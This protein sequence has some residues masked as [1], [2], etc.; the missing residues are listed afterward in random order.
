MSLQAVSNK[1]MPKQLAAATPPSQKYNP[2]AEQAF[3]DYWSLGTGRSLEKLVVFYQQTTHKVTTNF[4]TLAEWSRRYEWQRRVAER[5]EAE[6]EEKRHREKAEL[7]EERRN[8]RTLLKAYRGKFIERM[9]TFDL[10]SASVAEM[11]AVLRLLLQEGRSE[12]DDLPTEKQDTESGITIKVK[13]SDAT[14]TNTEE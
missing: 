8:R 4:R 5:T 13:Y 9:K 11:T 3:E 7:E 2:K 10:N 14:N 1:P 6:L 12:W